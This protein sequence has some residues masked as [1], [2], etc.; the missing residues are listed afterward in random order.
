[1][2][3]RTIIDVVEQ[4]VLERPDDFPD[5][6][7]DAELAFETKDPVQLAKIDAVVAWVGGIFSIGNPAVRKHVLDEIDYALFSMIIGIAA[8]IE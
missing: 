8:G 3:I 5:S 6:V 4:M 1:M 7:L 2:D